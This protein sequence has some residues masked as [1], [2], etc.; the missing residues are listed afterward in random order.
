MYTLTSLAAILDGLLPLG[1]GGCRGQ[2]FGTRWRLKGAMAIWTWGVETGPPSSAPSAV[3]SVTS[4]L[5]VRDREP[6]RLT[7]LSEKP[8]VGHTYLCGCAW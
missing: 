8:P 2:E 4:A 6:A 1:C 3:V 5:P 7:A